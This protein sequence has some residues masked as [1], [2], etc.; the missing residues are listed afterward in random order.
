MENAIIIIVLVA[1]LGVAVAYIVKEKRS[2]VKC[3][4]CPSG[5]RCGQRNGGSCGG[6]HNGESCD[7]REETK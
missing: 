3:I 1:I 7:C 4:G 2:G 5:G 6:C